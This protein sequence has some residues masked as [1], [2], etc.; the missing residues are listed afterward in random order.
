[1]FFSLID[2]NCCTDY[3]EIDIQTV[4]HIDISNRSTSKSYNQ[5]FQ[6][7]QTLYLFNYVYGM[8]NISGLLILVV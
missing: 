1:M 5:V 7:A 3:S 8:I 6:P 4:T 2:V